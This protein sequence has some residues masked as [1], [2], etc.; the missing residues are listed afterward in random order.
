[1]Q[2]ASI[3]RARPASP[4]SPAPAPL[5]P[6]VCLVCARKFKSEHRHNHICRG[7]TEDRKYKG[8]PAVVHHLAFHHVTG[9]L[10]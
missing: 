2:A 8:T 1:M 3:V 10:A 4:S 9:K 6:R 7:C 5:R